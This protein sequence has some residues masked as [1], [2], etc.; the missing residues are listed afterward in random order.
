M[1]AIQR[2]TLTKHIHY[3]EVEIIM[4]GLNL[5]DALTEEPSVIIRC[6]SGAGSDFIEANDDLRGIEY[7]FV[8]CTL[9]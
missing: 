5:K 8:D 1:T 2:V 7:N 9:W 3:D 6:E 4:G